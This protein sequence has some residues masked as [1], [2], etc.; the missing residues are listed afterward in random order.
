MKIGRLSFPFSLSGAVIAL[1]VIQLALVS[2]FAAKYLYQRWTCPLAWT[3][4]VAQDPQTPMHGRYLRLQLMV[5]GCQ[6]T[7]PSAKLATFPRDVNGAVK[8][9]QYALR[10]EPQPAYFNAYLKVVNNKLVAVRVEG[11]EDSTIGEGITA[12]PGTSCD[13]M[14]VD[15]PVDFY[16]ARHTPSPLPLKPGQELWVEVTLPPKGTPQPVQLAL[17]QDGVWKPLGYE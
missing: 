6:S 2:A 4:A 17:K 15:A 11:Q 3:R 5:D 8:P 16:L 13:Q 1:I 10:P 14:S 9:G 7:L 12:M